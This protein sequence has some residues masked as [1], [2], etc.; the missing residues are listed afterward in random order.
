M[1]AQFLMDKARRLCPDV[2]WGEITVL[3]TDHQGIRTINQTHLGKTDSTDVI[4]FRHSPMP[5]DQNLTTGD[6]V[7]NVECAAE[8]TD[9]SSTAHHE[10]ALYIA[11]GCDHLAGSTDED[12][13]SRR[14]MRRRELHWLK[15]A[16]THH[17][18]DNLVQF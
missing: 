11:H 2:S 1:L 5:G 7:V 8:L 14:R 13:A 10:L 6:I 9:S 4:S 18:L 16:T 3:V 15:E 17:L 12:T